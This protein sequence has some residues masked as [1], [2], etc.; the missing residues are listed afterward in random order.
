M[1]RG[2]PAL[3]PATNTAR[4]LFAEFSQLMESQASSHG[5][6]LEPVQ[7]GRESITLG[8]TL[9]AINETCSQTIVLPQTLSVLSA[10]LPGQVVAFVNSAAM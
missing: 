8:L 1:L 9:G 4:G 5:E 2:E 10:L 7:G 6:Q 3:E